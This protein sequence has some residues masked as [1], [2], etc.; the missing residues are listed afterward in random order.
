MISSSSRADSTTFSSSVS[1]KPTAIDCQLTDLES[2]VCNSQEVDKLR[3]LSR[4]FLGSSTCSKYSILHR[5]QGA[6]R[7]QVMVTRGLTALGSY[8]RLVA[9]VVFKR[10]QESDILPSRVSLFF[11]SQ[12]NLGLVSRRIRKPERRGVRELGQFGDYVCPGSHAST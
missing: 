2:L 6:D 1:E 7:F 8:H 3:E 11:R 10:M 12:T 5:I 9:R 4:L